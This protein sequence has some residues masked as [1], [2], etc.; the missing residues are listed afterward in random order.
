MI[1][2][3]TI[4]TQIIVVI[5]FAFSFEHIKD[6]EKELQTLDEIKII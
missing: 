1:Y 4:V 6:Y 2:I 3:N 5:F